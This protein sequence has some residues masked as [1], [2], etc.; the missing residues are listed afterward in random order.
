MNLNAAK[1]PTHAFKIWCHSSLESFVYTV[2]ILTLLD[3]IILYWLPPLFDKLYLY[4]DSISLNMI[5]NEL[6]K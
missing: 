5:A 1:L 6:S 4:D 3:L 2:Q